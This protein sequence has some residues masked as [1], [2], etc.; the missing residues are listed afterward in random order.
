MLRKRFCFSCAE[1]A[2]VEMLDASKGGNVRGVT[3]DHRFVMCD[4]L[5]EVRTIAAAKTGGAQ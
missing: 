5:K 3:E 1:V 4:E 2:L